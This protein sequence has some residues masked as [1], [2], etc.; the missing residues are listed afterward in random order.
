MININID[1]FKEKLEELNIK[2]NN[3]ILEKLEI[4]VN[5]LLEYNEHTNLTAIKNK[6][7]VYLKHFYDSLTIVKIIN[8]EEINNLL[9]IG[10]G[11][12]FPGMVLKIFYPHLN[13]TLLDSNNKKI[14]FLKLLG[15]KLKVTNINYVHDRAENFAKNNLNT[16]DL[17][18][19]RAV[20]SMRVLSELSLPLVKENGYF[21]A[22]KG[23]AEEEL[24]EANK[25]IFIMHGS[26]IKVINFNLEEAGSR[27]L[28][29]IQKNKLTNLKELRP[30]EKIIK[31]P[32]QNKGK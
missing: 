3:D 8:L 20:A 29:L 10:T 17:V 21:L 30:Y 24:K 32:L 11:A 19:S 2:Y 26:L 25:T 5:F 23:M 18:V 31:K 27:S 4:Y 22:M 13:V 6:D 28:I 14:T 12:G 15:D 16:F 7:D 1:K 9:D